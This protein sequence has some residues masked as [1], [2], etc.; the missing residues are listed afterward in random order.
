MARRETTQG[1]PRGTFAIRLGED[2][3]AAIAAAAG[4]RRQTLSAFVRNSAIAAAKHELAVQ[5]VGG[6]V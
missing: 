5:T 6:R 1:S 2:E 3:R 4:L